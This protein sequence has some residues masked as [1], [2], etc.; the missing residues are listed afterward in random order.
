MKLNAIAFGQAYALSFILLYVFGLVIGGTFGM[1][2]VNL[3]VTI[4]ANFVV[5]YIF[6][7]FYNS[8]LSRR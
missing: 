5:G 7:R 4:G 3:V 2:A 6:A 1:S 8:C